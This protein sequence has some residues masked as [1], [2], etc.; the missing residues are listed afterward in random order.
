MGQKY[1]CLLLMT[2]KELLVSEMSESRNV[3]S[4]LDLLIDILNGDLVYPIFDKKDAFDFHIAS[5][6]Y[7][8]RN[9][10]TAQL[11]VRTCHS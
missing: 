9:I 8:S 5:P 10:P 6:P 2:G 4:Y 11:M 3:V 7:L 1:F